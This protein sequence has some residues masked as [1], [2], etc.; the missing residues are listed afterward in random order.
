MAHEEKRPVSSQDELIIDDNKNDKQSI[1][2]EL[3][4]ANHEIED[5]KLQLAW[6]E[7]GA[8]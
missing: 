4:D 6:L 3:A 8:E 7:R 1:L 5:L 2:D